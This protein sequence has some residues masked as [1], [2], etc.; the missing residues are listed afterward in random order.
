MMSDQKDCGRHE[1][2][3]AAMLEYR[4]QAHMLLAQQPNYFGNLPELGIPPVVEIV[5]DT[6]F[7]EATCVAF[8]PDTDVLEAT[9]EV[10][11]AFGYGGDPCSP[12]STEWVR[13][14]LSYDDGATWE[15]V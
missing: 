2:A 7:E 11:R 13:F 10:K 5:A 12:G 4:Q 8:N 3:V 6:F 1:P 15:D 14:Y 9:I